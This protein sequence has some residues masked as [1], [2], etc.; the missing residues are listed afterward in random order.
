MKIYYLANYDLNLSETDVYPQCQN[1]KKGLSEQEIEEY[2][3]FQE[4]YDSPD[5]TFPPVMPVL[6]GYR[7]AGRAKLT[8]YVSHPISNLMLVSPK[9]LSIMENFNLGN[10]KTIPTEIVKRGVPYDYFFLYIVSGL[11]K[12]L[13]FEDFEFPDVMSTPKGI[14]KFKSIP[15]FKNWRSSLP[16]NEMAF[17]YPSKIVMKKGCPTDLDIIRIPAVH[18]GDYFFSERLKEEIEKNNLTGFGL[19]HPTEFVFE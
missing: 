10:Y 6:R 15:D 2:Y 9:A 4:Y 7:L 19:G 5:E 12:Y 11:F 14:I 16:I 1:F 17:M 13:K 8:D 3:P 18:P